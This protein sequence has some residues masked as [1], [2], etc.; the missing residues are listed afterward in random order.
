MIT[1]IAFR[2][3]CDLCLDETASQR[4]PLPLLHDMRQLVAEQFLALRGVRIIAPGSEVDVVSVS[5][6]PCTE[7][8]S[9]VTV[10]HAH[11]GEILSERGLHMVA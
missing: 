3:T 1:A 4:P 6:R 9:L 10:M 7:D 5:K 2:R 11:V 8:C